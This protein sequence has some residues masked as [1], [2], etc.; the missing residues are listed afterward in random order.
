MKL[1][2]I[3]GEAPEGDYPINLFFLPEEINGRNAM[4][5]TPGLK[6]F[7]T[8]VASVEVRGLHVVDDYLYAV[9]GN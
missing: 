3:T 9:C 6:L 2:F 5:G 8:P 1:P 7:A 4:V